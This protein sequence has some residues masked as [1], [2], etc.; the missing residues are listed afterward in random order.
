MS[1]EA[2]SSNLIPAKRMLRNPLPILF[3][4]AV[5][6]EEVFPFLNLATQSTN[7]SWIAWSTGWKMNVD[8]SWNEKLGWGGVGWIVRDSAK[9]LIRFRGLRIYEH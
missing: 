1:N 2:S 3:G 6:G 5:V 4:I 8:A 9:S 7:V